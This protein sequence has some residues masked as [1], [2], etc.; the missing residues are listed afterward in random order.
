[1][2]SNKKSHT[3]NTSDK[4]KT[5]NELHLTEFNNTNSTVNDNSVKRQ[6]QYPVENHNMISGNLIGF[7]IY[8]PLITMYI[9]L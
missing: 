1:V 2:E 7:V 8:L 5:T 6:Q 3:N 9:L 4:S